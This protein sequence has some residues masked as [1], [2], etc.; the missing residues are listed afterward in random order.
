MRREGRCVV[1][2]S[3]SAA[4]YVKRAKILSGPVCAHWRD[5]ECLKELGHFPNLTT[6]LSE[7][8][9]GVITSAG[10]AS[11]TELVI[12]LLAEFLALEDITEIGNRLLLQRLRRS[13]A[14]QPRFINESDL[15]LDSK[16]QCVVRLME[17]AIEEPLPISVLMERAG[18]CTRHMERKFR[19]FFNTTPSRF[20]KRLRIRKARL[21]I[22]ETQMNVSEIAIAT[23]FSSNSTFSKAFRKEYGT[24][25]HALR[26]EMQKKLL[27]YQHST[28]ADLMLPAPTGGH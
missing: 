22:D 20:Y 2:L 3:N 6:R 11:T 16:I 17:E 7:K 25:P 19:K 9:E 13:N 15:I 12:G 18:V 28:E 23:G 27:E 4:E 1:L 26:F 21:L 8:T 5:I 10:A 14:E 24:T